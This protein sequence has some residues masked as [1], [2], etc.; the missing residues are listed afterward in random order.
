MLIGMVF[1]VTPLKICLLFL[2]DLLSEQ[3]GAAAKAQR[4]TSW[5][6]CAKGKS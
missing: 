6:P 2:N 4:A 5:L 1:Y 3:R